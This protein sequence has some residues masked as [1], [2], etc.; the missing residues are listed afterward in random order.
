MVEQGGRRASWQKAFQPLQNGVAF[1]LSFVL[2]KLLA[3]ASTISLTTL[4]ISPQEV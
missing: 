1:V 4:K 2:Y 3:K